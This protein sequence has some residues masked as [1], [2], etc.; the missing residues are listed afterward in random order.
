MIIEEDSKDK[1]ALGIL[2]SILG[3][4]VKG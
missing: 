4:E 1:I 2:D 3:N